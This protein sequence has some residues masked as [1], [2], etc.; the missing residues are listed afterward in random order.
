MNG[1]HDMGHFFSGM[2]CYGP[3]EREENESLFHARWE[4]RVFAMTLFFMLSLT[5][6]H[7]QSG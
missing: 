6:R 2:T 3:V 1:P 7:R 5:W 4:K